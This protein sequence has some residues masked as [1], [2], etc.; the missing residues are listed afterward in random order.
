[1][2]RNTK[3]L[4]NFSVWATDGEIGHVKDMYF[5]DEAW[6]VRY[7]VAET[8]TWLSSRKVLV[9]PLSVR[10]LDWPEKILPVSLTKL[11]VESS[12]NIDTDKPVTRQHEVQYLGYYGHPYY[13]GGTG[14]WGDAMY[15]NGDSTAYDSDGPNWV[16]RQR[17]DE[18]NLAAERALHRNDDPHLRSCDFV[19]GYHVEANDGEIGHVSSFLVDEDSWAIR[20][21]I[22]NT[23]NWWIG[24]KV[25][26][27][28]PWITGVHWFEK[29][30][31]VDLSRNAVK[32]SPGYDPSS[33]MDRAWEDNLHKHFGSHRL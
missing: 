26:I 6:V 7:F 21:L 3:D 12:P 30:I 28:P 17:V 25:L 9:S 24:H 33:R 27:A 1:M 14:L 19:H 32:A 23:S 16:G 13:W 22:V 8:G 29:S 15:P 2:L 20:Y 31:S 10:R 4:K 18:A 11:Q 5:D